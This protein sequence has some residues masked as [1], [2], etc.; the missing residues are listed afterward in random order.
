[1][2]KQLIIMAI[3][4]FMGGMV[5]P[6]AARRPFPTIYSRCT[7]LRDRRLD[8]WLFLAC[9]FRLPYPT[10]CAVYDTWYISA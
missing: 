3:H 2:K 4:P 6:F 7:P 5:L 10:E 1:M 9:G 8:G